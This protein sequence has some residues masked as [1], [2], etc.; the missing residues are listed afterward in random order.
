MKNAPNARDAGGYAAGNGGIV[1][2]GLLYRSGKLSS[3]TQAECDIIRAAGIRTIIDLRSDQ[4]RVSAP[5]AACLLDFAQYKSIPIQSDASSREQA[6]RLF[7]SDPGFS[8][9]LGAIFAILAERE[10]L[11]VIIHCSAGKD[12]AGGITALIH[13]LLGVDPDDVM[14]DYLL[15]NRAGREVKAQW[16][17][18]ALDQV[19]AEG[20]IELLLSKR[21]IGPKT[22][23]A[24][25][26]NLLQRNS[27]LQ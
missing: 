8:A 3:I 2:R 12:R 13:L 27:D 14:A 7:I 18:A 23:M 20:G 25:R 6:Y 26:A 5:D 1:G 22:Q 4:E 15:S 21:G 24:V 9:Q 19:E 11:P 17:R 16:L 10:D